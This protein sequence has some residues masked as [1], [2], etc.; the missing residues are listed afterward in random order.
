MASLVVGT[1]F[2]LRGLPATAGGISRGG[3]GKSGTGQKASDVLMSALMQD[4]KDRVPPRWA[5]VYAIVHEDN[6]RSRALCGRF[7]LTVDMPRSHP[8]YRRIITEPQDATQD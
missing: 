3:K 6:E 1:V 2:G 8:R 5:R 7:G 4:V